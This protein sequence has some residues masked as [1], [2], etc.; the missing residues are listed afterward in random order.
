MPTP[1]DIPVLEVLEPSRYEA[2]A[3]LLDKAIAA[4]AQAPE[5]HYALALA[6]KR[7][8]KTNEARAALR[9]IARPDAN[10]FLQMGLLSLREGQVAQAE[11]EFARAWQMNPSS[12]AVGHNLLLSRLTLG[13]A[14]AC[15]EL[16]PAVRA[17]VPNETHRRLLDLLGDLLRNHRPEKP[18]EDRCL[19][20]LPFDSPIQSMTSAEEQELIKLFRGLGNLETTYQLLRTLA[21]LRPTSAQALE[22]HYECAL[23]RARELMYRGRWS[24]TVWLLEPRTRERASRPQQAVLHNLLGCCAFVTQDFARA[25]NHFELTIKQLGSDPRLRQNLALALEKNEELTEAE[26]Q[27]SRFFDL[28]ARTMVPAPPDVPRYL[29][30]LEFEAL[31]HLANVFTAKER[32]Q[33]VLNYLNRAV[34]LRPDDVDVQERLFH[35]YMA[36]KQPANARKTLN[37]MRDLRPD[38]PQ[39]DL[40][41]LNMVEVRNLSDIERM[42]GEIDRIMRRYPDDHRVEERALGLVGDVIPEMTTLCDKLTEQLNKVMNQVGNLPRYQID[43]GALREV[44]RELLKEFQK[45]LRITGK[46]LPLVK[47]DDQRRVI[48]DLVDHIQ[49]KIEA[50][51]S[52]GA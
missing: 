31:I 16:I 51:R 21:N 42:L 12:F 37:R 20:A 32:W 29:E 38:D 9:K 47:T 45:L 50:C 6:H 10:V 26:E 1:D 18:G 43:W 8:G 41:E 11:Q 2:A 5:V 44:M 36:A 35:S 40:Y 13:Q 34:R 7:Q 17:L 27:W 33:T 4:G 14:P 24:E 48:R 15:L 49:Q 28:L 30:G 19:I 23:A 39:L 25:V 3:L 46:C 22:A 52:M